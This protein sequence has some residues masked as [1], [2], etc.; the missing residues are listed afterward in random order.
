MPPLVSF[1]APCVVRDIAWLLLAGEREFSN[2]G[3]P[4][5]TG[6]EVS[7]GG[8]LCLGCG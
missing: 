8:I 5:D 3:T 7:R 4:V 6:V 2:G 1:W